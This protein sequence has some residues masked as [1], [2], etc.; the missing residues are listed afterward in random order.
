MAGAAGLA[1]GTRKGSADDL[2]GTVRIVGRCGS[3]G[4]RGGLLFCSGLARPDVE[5]GRIHSSV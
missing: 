1:S 5:S 3:L 4:F 2:L